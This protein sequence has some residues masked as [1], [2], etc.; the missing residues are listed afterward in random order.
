MRAKG[1]PALVGGLCSHQGVTFSLDRGAQFVIFP[2]SEVRARDTFSVKILG[3]IR[4]P[5]ISVTGDPAPVLKPLESISVGWSGMPSGM[6]S[7]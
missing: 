4:L 2:L 3:V 1:W 6:W 7:W 5:N